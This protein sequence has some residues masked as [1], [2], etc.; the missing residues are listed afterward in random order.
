MCRYKP[1]LLLLRL[2]LRLRLL[3]LRLRLLRLLFCSRGIF[4]ALGGGVW[5]GLGDKK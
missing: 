3:L 2:L 1:I 5:H 4:E